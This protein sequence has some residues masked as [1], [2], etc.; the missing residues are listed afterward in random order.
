[1]TRNTAKMVTR[2]TEAST[3]G[4]N[5]DDGRTESQLALAKSV[6]KGWMKSDNEKSEELV[7][8][9]WVIMK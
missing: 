9:S 6:T 4:A 1:M 7:A 2:R 5:V 8:A 3:T